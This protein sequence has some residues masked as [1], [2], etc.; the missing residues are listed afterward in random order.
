MAEKLLLL[1]DSFHP[2]YKAGGPARSCLNIAYGLEHQ[3]QINVLTKDRDLGDTQPYPGILPDTW[4]TPLSTFRVCYCSPSAQRPWSLLRLIRQTQARVLYLNSMFSPVFTV[5]PLLLLRLGLWSGRVVLAPRGMLKPSALRVKNKKKRL[6]LAVFRALRVHKHVH[7]HATNEEEAHEVR[8]QFGPSATV[9]VL[10]NLP[11]LALLRQRTV[12]E[13][14][15]DQPL[16]FCSVAR[17]HP[18]KNPL[19]LIRLFQRARFEQPVELHFVGPHEV[20]DYAAQ[21][22]EAARQIPH[23]VR[24]FFHGEQPPSATQ[25]ILQNAHFFALLTQGEN[26]GHAIYEALALGKPVLISDQTPWRGL[27]Q[28]QAGWDMALSD[29]AA[30]TSAFEKAAGMATAQYQDWSDAA[31]AFA[32]HFTAQTDWKKSYLDMFGSSGV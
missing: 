31:H 27:A 28:H 15:P 14:S 13:K 30:M 20:P 10:P 19:L 29:E 6:F 17:L 32:Q 12:L 16:R 7:F 1:T 26:F 22:V 21:C 8:Y 3:A 24:V 23:N 25:A 2:G 5:L 11:D 18:I 4:L 9:T